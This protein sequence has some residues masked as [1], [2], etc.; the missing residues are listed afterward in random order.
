MAS[1]MQD[2]AN[3]EDAG[4]STG[5]KSVEGKLIVSRNA[6]KHGIFSKD[7]IIS[8]GDG[9]EDKADFDVLLANLAEDL[10]PIGKLEE[11]LVE[12]IAVNYWRLR[13]LI[14]FESGQIR[15][16]LD[17]YRTQAVEDFYSGDDDFYSSS[18]KKRKRPDMQFYSYADYI[19]DEEFEE[20][21]KRVEDLSNDSIDFAADDAFLKYVLETKFHVHS[22]EDNQREINKARKYVK[23]LSPQM[24]GKYRSAYASFQ[25]QLWE[26]MRE[27]KGWQKKFEIVELMRSIP[28]NM[29]IDK[30]IKYENSL[31]RSIFRNLAVLSELQ[32]RRN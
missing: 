31:E 24:L 22:P 19:S 3:R 20:Q 15:D 30:I 13:R 7:I 10:Q 21:K 14:R 18:R 27:V 29:E 16:R 2:T 5:P 4:T 17:E 6:I 23:E 1:E 8:K 12:K 28:N 11:L 26:E 25:K 9:K 32:K